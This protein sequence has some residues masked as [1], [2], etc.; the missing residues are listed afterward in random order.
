MTGVSTSSATNSTTA[1]AMA[2]RNT[3]RRRFV[4]A[5]AI[6][7][8][9]RPRAGPPHARGIVGAEEGRDGQALVEQFATRSISFGTVPTNVGVLNGART[10]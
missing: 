10:A 7:P 5:G 9:A 3:R 2:P 6:L 4:M 1:A 8:P